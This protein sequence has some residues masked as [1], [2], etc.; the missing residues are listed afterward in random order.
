MIFRAESTIRTLLP[1]LP[2]W[3]RDSRAVK[4]RA[5]GTELK[6]SFISGCLVANTK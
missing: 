1:V 2:L 6:Y 4:H 5:A 3:L